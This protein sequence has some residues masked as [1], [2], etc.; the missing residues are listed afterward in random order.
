MS[1]KAIRELFGFAGVIG[2][3]VFVGLEVRQN[4]VAARATAYQDMGSV[5]SGVWLLGAQDPELAALTLRFFEDE[6]AE[7]T[8]E[9]EAVLVVQGI[10]AFRQYETVW[11]QVQLGLLDR[12]VLGYFGWDTGESILSGNM[13]RLWPR[14][15]RYM[16]PDFRAY[17]EGQV[18]R[19]E[20]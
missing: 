8:T 7:F 1:G 9:E 5:I 18:E 3:L 4:T 19:P 10:G 20:N 14:M 11:R 16:S 12:E 2:S 15:R 6:E 17:L 13:K